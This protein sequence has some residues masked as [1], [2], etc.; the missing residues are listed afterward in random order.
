MKR[1]TVEGVKVG[2]RIVIDLGTGIF[3]NGV[4]G[5]IPVPKAITNQVGQVVNKAMMRVG[6][7]AAGVAFGEIASEQLDAL[8]DRVFSPF[9]DEK[10]SEEPIYE[11]E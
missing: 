8:I 10:E 9:I 2:T 6:M 4:A 7:Q 5:L 1:S 11:T 3:F